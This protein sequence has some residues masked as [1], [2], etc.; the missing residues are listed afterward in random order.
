M[1]LG[2]ALVAMMRLLP[3]DTATQATSTEARWQPSR[4]NVPASI[5]RTF[6]LAGISTFVAFSVS[7]LFLTL[8]PSYVSQVA[9]TG[10]LALVGGIVTVMFGCA[11]VVQLPLRR[12]STRRAQTLGLALL[13]AGL[14]GL[15]AA[16]Q[17][18]SLAVVLAATVVTGLGQG[19]AFGGSLAAVNA[20]APAHRRGDVLSSYYV[21][22]Y[23]GLA[24]PIIGVGF[25]ALTTGQLIAVQ[26]FA[27]AII[28]A[29]LAGIAAHCLDA[30]RANRLSSSAL[31]SPPP[32][33]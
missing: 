3:H 4:P 1:L 12:L 21:I 10:N 31:A 2:V 19:L 30:R 7:A 6:T 17:T 11:A 8:M 28:G 26:I 5:R 29:C 18:G 32:G 27:Y 20:V 15:I 14:A 13:V 23:L 22:V 33:E 25:I 16:A 24:V 9:G